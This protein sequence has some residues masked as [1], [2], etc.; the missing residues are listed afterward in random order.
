MKWD[1]SK[2]K[3]V[4][5]KKLDGAINCLDISRNNTLAVG[6]RNGVVSFFDGS[7]LKFIKNVFKH[8][9]PDKDMISTVKF[10]PDGNK[11]AV[12]Y[13]PP[14]S[15]IYIYDV[16][17]L[18]AAPKKCIGSS[19]RINS[20]DFSR[21]GNAILINNTSYEILFYDSNSGQQKKSAT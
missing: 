5:K 6:M 7:S 14:F 3:C 20:I 8:K 9:N 18:D 21:N 12:A 10:S 16:N 17:N 19:S 13:A 1:T 4:D 11:L 15:C 2:R